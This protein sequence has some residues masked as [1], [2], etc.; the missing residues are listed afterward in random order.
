M[1]SNI[2]VYH[3]KPFSEL[4]IVTDC[5]YDDS[6]CTPSIMLLNK[7]SSA[8]GSQCIIASAEI[9][10][11][12][13]VPEM[14]VPI[15]AGQMLAVYTWVDCSIQVKGVVQQEYESDDNS[16]KEYLNL[17][18]SINAVRELATIRRTHGPRILITGAPSSGK[19]SICM[20]LGNYSVRSGWTP[21]F[22]EADPRS[23][24]DKKSLQFYPGT[25]GATVLSGV[26]DVSP[27]NPIVYF[28]GHTD[29]QENETL[30]L[31]TCKCLATSI[32]LM[33]EHNLKKQPLNRRSD[34]VNDMGKYIAA[35]GMIINAPFQAGRDTIMHLAKIFN[36]T[37]II[38]VDSQSIHQDLVKAFSLKKHNNQTTL[39]TKDYVPTA[40]I[41]NLAFQSQKNDP[42]STNDSNQSDVNKAGEN[43]GEK[44]IIVLS[45]SKLQGVVPV[46][47]DRL[48]FLNS[49]IWKR[50]FERTFGDFHV[51]RFQM[52][53]EKFVTINTTAGLSKDALAIDE[54]SSLK[55]E[56]LYVT[57]W[58]GDYCSLIN[59]VVAIPS[60]EDINLIPY[61][62]IT[63]FFHLR[64]IEEINVEGD[65][66]SGASSAKSYNVEATCHSFYSASSLPKY[67]LVPGNTRRIRWQTNL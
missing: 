40:L 34:E 17:I 51:I 41:G 1:D 36:V 4:R 19:S 22:V 3:L 38:V 29:V 62:N 43:T 13:L 30:Y 33:M 39:D 31:N 21:V 56:E 54:E 63:G 16:M 2:R 44:E 6:R 8:D 7:A 24:T 9:F 32:E 47:N 15:E 45:A 61:C 67:L 14:E 26:Q 12:E 37:M 49:M 46:D 5:S 20:I 50:Y 23:S 53:I 10:G 27:P 59:C 57:Q 66:E 52:E 60:T 65:I 64:S 18:G 11:K 35:S 58:S 25:I 42:K 48:K 28:Y 55:S